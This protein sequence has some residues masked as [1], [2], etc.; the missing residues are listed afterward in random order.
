[1][2][3]TF[4]LSFLFCLLFISLT[5]AQ[6]FKFAFVTDTHIGSNNAE[7]DLERTV[8]DI[9]VQSDIDFVVITGDITEMGTNKEL[10]LAKEILKKI[11]IPYYII[12]GNHD[13]GWSESGGVSFIKEFGADKFVFEHNGFKIIGCASGPYVRMSDGHI[14]RDAVIWLKKVLEETPKNQPII[15]LN[16]Y[17]IDNSLDN[18][19]EATDLLKNYNTQFVICGH[20][21]RNKKMN[22][23]GIPA[24]MAVSY[25]HLTL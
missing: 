11:K 22:F 5:F 14:P 3:K 17:P 6:N 19:Y 15:F 25:T 4:V 13:T 20:G 21:H 10:A 1:M 16:H 12:P 7:E 9:N 8:A 2:K 23:E 24:S 18:W